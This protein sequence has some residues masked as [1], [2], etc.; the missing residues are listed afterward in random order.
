MIVITISLL[1]KT[2]NNHLR[3]MIKLIH[4]LTFRF[5]ESY[6]SLIEEATHPLISCLFHLQ[7]VSFKC[8]TNS[9]SLNTVLHIN[10]LCPFLLHD[11]SYSEFGV[12]SLP[13]GILRYVISFSFLSISSLF[14]STNKRSTPLCNESLFIC[15]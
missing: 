6:I 5:F 15:S 9:I 4:Q 2:I 1:K 11:Y 3:I 8:E 13:E 12:C 14:D 10:I 7:F